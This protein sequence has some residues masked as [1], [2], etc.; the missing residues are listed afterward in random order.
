MEEVRWVGEEYSQHAPALNVVPSFL[1]SP[2]RTC[3]PWVISLGGPVVPAASLMPGMEKTLVLMC[4]TDVGTA[5][6]S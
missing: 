2:H 5:P 4:G 1:D 6:C 3:S